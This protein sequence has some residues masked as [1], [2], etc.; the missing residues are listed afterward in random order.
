MTEDQVRA[1]SDEEVLAMCKMMGIGVHYDST[2]I[3]QKC[4]LQ[5]KTHPC[6][7]DGNGYNATI[8][9]G[10]SLQHAWWR[11]TQKSNGVRVRYVSDE[12]EEE[13]A[14]WLTPSKK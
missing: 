1:M 9:S 2:S 5:H 3:L 14:K 8:T 13:Y 10:I 7:C 12:P 11:F 6:G 4:T